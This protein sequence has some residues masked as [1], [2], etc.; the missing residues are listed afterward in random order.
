MKIRN[1][2]VSNSSSSSFVVIQQS[3]DIIVPDI[4]EDWIYI[5]TTFGGETKFEWQKN[6]YKDIGSKI[7][8]VMLQSMYLKDKYNDMIFKLIMDCYPNVKDITNAFT[9]NFDCFSRNYGSIDHQSCS[10]E[11]KNIEMFESYDTLKRFIFGKESYIQTGND[12]E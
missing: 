2:F 4:F 5:P 10:I 1:G 12:N 8:F 7:N 9:F 6:I 11:G 3:N